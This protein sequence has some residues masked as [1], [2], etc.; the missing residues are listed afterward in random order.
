LLAG[1]GILTGKAADDADLKNYNANA[2]ESPFS[3]MGKY[4]Y[5]W[6]MPF[7]IPLAIGVE[8]YNAVKGTEDEA[9][10]THVVA[11]NKMDK[12][13]EIAQLSSDIIY[14]SLA[15]A[16]DTTFNMSVM[17]SIKTLLANPKGFTAG[18]AQLPQNYASQYI[19][20][21]FGQVAGA[22]DPT[23]RKS[24]VS[25]NVPQSIAA[26]V[27]SKTPFLSKLA[28]PK[29]TPFGE[30]TKRIEN[31]LGRLAAQL[32]SPGNISVDQNIDPKI[33]KEI[34]RLGSLGLTEQIPTVVPNYV[35]KTQKHPKINLSPSETTEYQKRTG[36][37]TLAAFKEVINS[38]E[39]K[40]AT[41]DTEKNK[42]ADEVKAELLAKAVKAAKAQ[43]KAELL[44]KK[45]YKDT[46]SA[47]AYQPW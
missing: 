7:A 1:G 34:K 18:L 8:L 22:I 31:P 10:L 16:G 13:A 25:G 30:D 38:D 43:A 4:T 33:D 14:N 36:K 23:V 39:Y 6:A 26:G 2:G 29:Q 44:S 12:L 21:V 35:E 32:F 47:G 42:T 19:P 3:I 15:A 5:D 40:Y 27:E 11:T 24:Y 20:T 9:K 41:D 17:K 46:T 28:E 45:G 37:L